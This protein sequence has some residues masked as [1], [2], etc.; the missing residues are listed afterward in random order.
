ME[1]SLKKTLLT[2]FVALAVSAA[3]ASAGMAQQ[4]PAATQPAPAQA[5]IEKFNGV[6]EK[7]DPASKEF[8]VQFHKESMTFSAGDHT[9]FM[10][11][12]KSLPFSDLKK[13]MWASIGYQKEGDKW[14]AE[15]VHVSMPKA[16]GKHMTMAQAKGEKKENPPAAKQT[17]SKEV[18]KEG[19]PAAPAQGKEVQKEN[20]APKATE[21]K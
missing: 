17:E 20:P 2:G 16:E 8:V 3:F 19:T 7:V 12:A 13:G 9:K 18:K 11:G 10:E 15:S 5:K 6:I 1:K 21:K 4:S 14:I